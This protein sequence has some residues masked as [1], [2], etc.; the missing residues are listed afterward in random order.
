MQLSIVIPCY[1]EEE[2]ISFFY[3]AVLPVVQSLRMSYELIFVND[4]SK[5][6]T[7]SCLM[8]LYRAHPDTIRVIDFSRNFGK[9]AALLAG[10]RAC[11]GEYVAVMDAD[12]QDPPA[13]L[14]KMFAL[15]QQNGDDVVGTR[16]VSR[17]GEPP[18]RSWFARRFY[19]LINRYAEVEIV[20]G[21]RDFRLMKR[22]V[23]EAILSLPERNR[24]SK[25]LFV[26]VG[27]KTE[28]L[29]Y[30]NIQRVAG[31]TKWSFR[32]LVEYAL[33]GIIEYTMA[34]LWL[35]CIG[36]GILTCIMTLV[37]LGLLV[38]SFWG[39]R[40]SMGTILLSAL[41][42]SGGVLLAGLGIVGAYLA[43]TYDEVRARPMYVIRQM[44]GEKDE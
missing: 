29:A 28:Y 4:G 36:G 8:R 33:D 14:P 37:L 7:L 9:E 6:K 24:F 12:L 20:D 31:E 19:A 15:M 16:R 32:K 1:N 22:A 3:D 30:E 43:K 44:Y 34:P 17:I 39:V 42:W 38:M 27:F 2:T 23:V 10:L 21:A 25:G 13:L 35:A 40:F 41:L 5:D 18:I 11:R 26:W